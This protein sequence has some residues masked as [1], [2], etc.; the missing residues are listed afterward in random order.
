V[1]RSL[2]DWARI[3]APVLVLGVVIWRVGT[4]PFLTGIRSIDAGAVSMAIGIGVL[5][6]VFS[7]WRWTVV[8]AGL[9]ATLPLRSAIAAYYRSQFLNVVLPGGVIGD[10]HRGISHGRDKGDVGRGLRAVAWERSA[11]Q[12]VQLV[13]TIAVLF[14]LA[15]PVR[16]AVPYVAAG[17]VA[18]AVVVALVARTRPAGRSRWARFRRA[19]GHDLREVMLDRRRWPAIALA[20][21]VV[22]AGHAATFTIA[23]R[24]AGS[25]APLSQLLPIAL[26]A[27]MAMVLP[28]I[29]GW[30]PREGVTAWAFGAAG[31]GVQLGVATA[32]VYGVITFAACLPGAAVL[33]AVWYR[34]TR[35]P[36]SPSDSPSVAAQEPAHGPPQRSKQPVHA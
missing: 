30:G 9:G 22:V 7:A 33:V 2:R 8:S 28:S 23:A 3:V 17:L 24:T 15:S 20:S 14:T 5:T 18:A 27:M 11:G 21:T 31:L 34:R 25:G 1:N 13:L 6:T 29:G 16:S 10:V 35:Q 19:F 32:V 4:G 36:D 12:V 26:L